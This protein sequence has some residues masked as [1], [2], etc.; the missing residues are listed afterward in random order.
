[1]LAVVRTPRTNLRMRGFIPSRVLRVLRHEFGG[2]LTIKVEKEDTQVEN[3]FDSTMYKEFKKRATPADY[4]RT[5]REN[6]NLTQTELAE[7]LG[8]SRAYICDI[9]HGR[10]Q[11]SRQFARQLANFFKISAGNFI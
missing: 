4:V 1:M 2:H 6:A 9:E 8:I 5:Y 3:V 7:R 11:V 10:R